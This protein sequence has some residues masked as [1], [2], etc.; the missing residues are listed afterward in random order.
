[1]LQ[2]FISSD[3]LISAFANAKTFLV[4]WFGLAEWDDYA[5]LNKQIKDQI[6][7]KKTQKRFI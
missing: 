2:T 7:Y 1:M 5:P 6:F 3:N 4:K